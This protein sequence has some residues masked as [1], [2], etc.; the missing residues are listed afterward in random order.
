MEKLKFTLTR[1]AKKLGGDR[2]E[3]G[4]KGDLDFIVI[5]FPQFI[6]RKGGE[7]R[8]ELSLIISE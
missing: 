3:H 6:S 7:I 1:P 4:K 2:Y 8:K 5:Y